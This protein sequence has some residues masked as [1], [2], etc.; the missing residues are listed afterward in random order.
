MS[1]SERIT[2]LPIERV[3]L[4]SVTVGARRR[5]KPTRIPAL[6]R[7]IEAHGL[8]HPI[9]LRNG[10]ELV[11]GQRRLEACRSLGW[12]TIPARLIDTLSD[13]DLRALELD[14]NVERHD[15]DDFETSKARLLELEQ[16]RAQAKA[17]AE[18]EAQARANSAASRR[19]KSPHR[20]TG[21]KRTGRPKGRTPGSERDVAEE[22]GVS[23]REQTRVEEHVALADR[24]PL[25][26]RPGWARH[27]V[28]EAGTLLEA[29]PEK[30]HP[31]IASLLDQ[32]G[33]P[34]KKAIAILENL[35]HQ[36][37][38]QT[39]AE[40]Y[41]DAKNPDPHVRGNA[42]AKAAAKASAELRSNVE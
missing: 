26:Q 42:L 10:N 21:G 1:V 6:A 24:F 9:L 13:A 36:V 15:L 39:R 29:L 11:T 16:A 28:L 33:I 18:A 14:E 22:T 12:T 5:Q 31:V 32:D 38:P 20:A 17:K 2:R 30:E 41:R 7:S 4:D 23:P 8:I 40:I 3:R 19:R 34:P 35:A 27:Q 25:F 37:T